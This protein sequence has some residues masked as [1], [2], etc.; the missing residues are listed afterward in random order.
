LFNWRRAYQAGQYELPTRLPV[1]VAHEE[2]TIESAFHCQFSCSAR[3]I[4]SSRAPIGHESG[5]PLCAEQWEALTR[6]RDD[7]Q[8]V[9]DNLPVERTLRGVVVG[10]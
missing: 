9:I 7:G 3:P 1:E 10:Q 5:D 2:R 8:F 4:R 6:Y